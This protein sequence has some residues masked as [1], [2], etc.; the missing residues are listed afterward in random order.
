MV[1]LV[2]AFPVAVAFALSGCD[3]AAPEPKARTELELQLAR[4]ETDQNACPMPAPP[5]PIRRVSEGGYDYGECSG[6]ILAVLLIPE[7]CDLA[8]QAESAP[9]ED[10][11]D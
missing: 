3:I 11:G 9:L 1:R 5:E 2:L 7:P 4:C 8:W 10:A 6:M